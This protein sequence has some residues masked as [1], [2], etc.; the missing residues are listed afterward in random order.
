MKKLIILVVVAL[1]GVINAQA[2][3][4][5]GGGIAYGSDVEEF[6]LGVNGEF[7]LN[8]KVAVSPSLIVY[9]L[10]NSDNVDRSFWELNTN[11]NYYFADEGALEVYALGGLNLATSKFDRRGIDNDDDSRTELGV[12]LGIGTNFDINSSI[13]PFAQ[14]KFVISDFDQAVLFFGVRFSLK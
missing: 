5:L 11:V 3:Y 2:Q 7:F 13:K 12:N 6:G 8:S 9:F 14:L 1:T 10:E 4:R